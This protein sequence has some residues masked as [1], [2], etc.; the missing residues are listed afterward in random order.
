MTIANTIYTLTNTTKKNTDQMYHMTR[1]PTKQWFV[2]V[3]RVFHYS[4]TSMVGLF[5]ETVILFGYQDHLLSPTINSSDKE[6][7]YSY[8]WGSKRII[9]PKCHSKFSLKDYEL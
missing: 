7:N 3:C 5:E 9:M 6:H 8:N 1:M 2:C 4:C